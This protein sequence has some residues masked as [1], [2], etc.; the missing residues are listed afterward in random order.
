M[1]KSLKQIVDYQIKNIPI[2]IDKF[3]GYSKDI[4]STPHFHDFEIEIQFIKEGDGHY[5]VKNKKYK[6]EKGKVFIIHKKDL[7]YFIPSEKKSKIEK[8]TIMMK[9]DILEENVKFFRDIFKCKN[10]HQI[11][12]KEKDFLISELLLE[13]IYSKIRKKEDIK[14]YKPIFKINLSK[15]FLIL[16]NELERVKTENKEEIDARIQQAIELLNKHFNKK[17]S[18]DVVSNQIGLSKYYFSHLFKRNTGVSFK[19][20]LIEKRLFEVVKLIKTT[21]LKINAIPSKCGFSNYS[22]FFREFKKKFNIT[23][24]QFRNL[25]RAY[26]KEKFQ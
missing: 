9:K 16:Q 20:Y 5:F 22:L 4:I 6:I 14:K 11:Y 8:I 13:E 24:N 10:L 7:H 17:I 18:E 3:E 1:R 21:N 23:P 15:F 12:L 2:K 26:M 25:T 19:K